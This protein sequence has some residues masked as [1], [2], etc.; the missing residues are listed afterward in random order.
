MRRSALNGVRVAAAQ[1]AIGSDVDV[2]LA[3]CLRMVAAAAERG[4]QLVVLPAYCNHPVWYTDRAHADRVACRLDGEFL[5]R[6]AAV[7]AERELYVKLHVTLAVEDRI[8]AANLLFDPAGELIART[9]AHRLH[10]PES[11]WLDSVPGP[12]RVVETSIGRIG[13]YAGPDGAQPDVPRAL[14]V[15]GAQLLLASLDSVATDDSRLHLPV[16]AAENKV[17]VVAANVVGARPGAQAQGVPERWFVGAGES[18]LFAPDGARVARAPRLG[19][20]V[21]VA[22]IEPGWA[23]DKTRPDGGDLFLARRPRLYAAGRPPGTRP[24]AAASARVAVLRP[25]G[26]GMAAIEDAGRL[27]R[28]AAANGVELAVL[29]EL[30]HYADGRADGSFLDGIA[31]DVISQALEDTACHV[32]TSLP[33]D[34]AH[35]G[36]LISERGVTGRQVQMHACGRHISWQAALGDRLVRFDLPWGRLVIA[37]GDDALF[38]EVFQLA[39]SLGAD[40]VAV[41][42]APAE[43]WELTLGLPARAAENNLNIVA[44][45]HAGPGG[46]GAIVVPVVDPFLHPGRDDFDGALAQPQVSPVLVGANTVTGTIYPARARPSRR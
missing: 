5:S 20:T 29:P 11:R 35:V 2:N 22:D 1:F 30:F 6:I 28:A 4:A 26:H 39:V 19:E 46:G 8:T 27:V 40:A 45:A 18:G 37:V 7:A 9:D 23:D 13:M 14:A 32:V 3:S 43:R 15:A 31:V 10:G 44:A 16:R 25:N 21:V 41:P 24:P 33:D 36:V 17:W 38:P 42:C 12:G 34:A